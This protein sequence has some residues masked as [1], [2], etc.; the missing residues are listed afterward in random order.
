LGKEDDIAFLFVALRFFRRVAEILATENFEINLFG[1]KEE[2]RSS[3]QA[4]ALFLFEYSALFY[5]RL[6]EPFLRYKL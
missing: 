1:S 6:S 5:L 3:C 2:P 4:T